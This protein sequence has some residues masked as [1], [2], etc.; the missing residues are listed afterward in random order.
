MSDSEESMAGGFIRRRRSTR[1]AA[2]DLVVD[3]Q[4]SGDEIDDGDF[5]S[6]DAESEQEK[7][8]FKDDKSDSSSDIEITQVNME[9]CQN[10]VEELI[11]EERPAKKNRKRTSVKKKED[12]GVP[13]VIKFYNRM[14]SG[15]Q[16]WHPE[17]REVFE[18]LAERK[19]TSR[20]A[21]EQ[22]PGLNTQL[23][24]FQKEGLGW[25]IRQERESVYKGGILA[26]E[27]GMGKTIQAI[28][29]FLSDKD[30]KTDP[31]LVIAPTVA[32]MQWRNEIKQYSSDTFSVL[33]Y[34]GANRTNDMDEVRKADIVLT[35]YA[36]VES[37]HRKQQSGFTRKGGKVYEKSVLHSIKF[38]RIV[39][40]EAHNIKDRQAG[41]SRAVFMLNAKYRLCLSGTPLQNRIGELYSLLRFL[42]VEPFC[43]YYCTK[44][45][46][47][48]DEWK[49]ERQ[50]CTM[51]GHVAM[52]H[53]NYFN[54]SLLKHIQRIEGSTDFAMSRMRL[55][56]SHIML[57]RT[58]V[59]RADDLGLPPRVVTVR[60]DFF[61][62]EEKDLYSSVFSNSR[63]EFSTYV[64]QGV[65]LNNYANI[66]TLITRM[67]Q[68]ADHP[69]LVLRRK[70]DKI[71]SDFAGHICKLCDDE[72]EDA[73]RSRCNHTFCRLCAREYV[74]G[75]LGREQDLKCPVCHV[76]L[77]IDLSAPAIEIDEA[78]AQ[79]SS[80]VNRIIMDDSWRSS[81]KIEALVEN[82]FR[83]RSDRQT[84]KSI[85][86][87]QFTSMLDLVEWRL[88]RA[89]FSTV[90][91][92]GNMSPHQRDSI[93]K[94]FMETPSVEVFLVSLKAGGVA[95]NLCE[96]SQVF[97]LDP[98][99]NPSVEWQSGDRVHRIGQHRPVKITRLIIEDSIE[100][101]IIELQAKK[102]NMINATIGSDDA[103]LNRL[104]KDDM[105]FLFQN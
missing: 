8:G 77:T 74:E 27:M 89:G 97:L 63:R 1:V 14:E 51:C 31:I 82:L 98:W 70:T 50:K 13:K 68:I 45:D 99:W 11:E 81:T 100:S 43:R 83:L 5:G 86:F 24:P 16:E 64:N 29:L 94:H 105:E 80:I 38:H 88:A 93:I 62:A 76:G 75:F 71:A 103:A 22:P 84:T 44:C 87:S 25:L 40:D 33:V 58:K 42:R 12:D 34:H 69:D 6:G 28:A 7:G 79:K 30:K 59:E 56:L 54:H 10:D 104:S 72:A 101:R 23:L 49:V 92:Q 95:L 17:L 67:R 60:R 3:L 55:L 37:V 46:C 15:L 48:S 21:V 2:E 53:V 65:V 90:K 85:V 4:S 57:R 102:A 96:A 9:L 32:V 18:G 39:L 41:T 61:N 20:E 73:I 66:F 26:D 35:T 91:L 36:V 78:E 52:Q 19:L 47:R